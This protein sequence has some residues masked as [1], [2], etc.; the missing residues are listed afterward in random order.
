M[1]SLLALGSR[2]DG[3]D[4]EGGHGKKECFAL[5]NALQVIDIS[6]NFGD[7]KSLITQ[8]TGEDADSIPGIRL[9]ETRDDSWI[10]E[11]GAGDVLQEL[12]GAHRPAAGHQV[13][14]LERA[15]AVGQVHVAQRAPGRTG[16]RH[17]VVVGAG[18]VREVQRDVLVVVVRRVPAGQVHRHP[19]L[20]WLFYPPYRGHQA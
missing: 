6:N 17:R 5:L 13:L 15:R 11:A 8:V 18:R 10:V 1:F 9:L 2:R 3:D 4:G 12:R 14:V 7:A 19:S 16:H 20:W